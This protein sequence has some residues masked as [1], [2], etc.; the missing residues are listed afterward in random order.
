MTANYN[1]H[2]MEHVGK[3]PSWQRINQ[4]PVRLT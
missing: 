3:K 2:A 1:Q 4:H